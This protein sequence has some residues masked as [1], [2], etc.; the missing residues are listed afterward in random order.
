[1]QSVLLSL[2]KLGLKCSEELPNKKIDIKNVL[3]KLN[4]IK[5]TLFENKT[6]VSNIFVWVLHDQQSHQKYYCLICEEEKVSNN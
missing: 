1:M 2:I 4:K 3:A 6:V 5:L